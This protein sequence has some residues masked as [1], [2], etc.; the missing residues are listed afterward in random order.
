MANIILFPFKM[1]LWLL[2]LPIKLVFT[3][4][5]GFWAIIAFIVGM[6][7]VV[8]LI[9]VIGVVPACILW[10]IGSIALAIFSGKKIA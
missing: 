2:L 8:P 6:V 1:L 5:A 10:L 7:L 3:I 4:F 9:I